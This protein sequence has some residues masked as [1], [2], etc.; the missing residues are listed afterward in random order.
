MHSSCG[1]QRCLAAQVYPWLGTSNSLTSACDYLVLQLA[2]DAWAVWSSVL[3]LVQVMGQ[4][5]AGLVPGKKEGKRGDT[6][7]MPCAPAC[8]RLSLAP[9]SG[10]E[11]QSWDV[12]GDTS[13]GISAGV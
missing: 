1:A 12:E 6:A 9:C 3:G 7:A 8:A 11:H 13:S 10:Q 5:G 2:G 4:E